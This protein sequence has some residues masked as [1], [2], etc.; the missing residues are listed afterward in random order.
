MN[1]VAQQLPN[2][3]KCA[4]ETVVPISNDLGDEQ[5]NLVVC[6]LQQTTGIIGVDF[7]RCVR[8]ERGMEGV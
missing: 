3:V 2:K 8:S 1:P 7:S 6:A 4:V 5:R